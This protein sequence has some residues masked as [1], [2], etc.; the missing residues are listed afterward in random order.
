MNRQSWAED[1]FVNL[2]L[3]DKRLNTRLINICDRFSESPESPIN[4]ACNDWAETKGAYRFFSN[5]KVVG[6]KILRAHSSQTVERS[7]KYKTILALQ[8]TSYMIYTNHKATKGIGKI[9]MKKGKNVDK[10][11]SKGLILHSCLAVTTDGL[12]LGLLDQSI[13]SRKPLTTGK[14]TKKDLT[15]IEKKESY[16]WLKTLRNSATQLKGSQVVTV[17]DREADIYEFFHLSN[18]IK[19]PVL[20]RANHNRAI[21]KK[22]RYAEKGVVKLW[23]YMNAKPNVG[24]TKV[25][26]TK[27]S[28]T[29]HAVQRKDR[30]AKLTIKVGAFLFNPPRNNIK[31]RKGKLP[32]LK[33]NAI[34]VLEENPPKGEKPLE[35][36]LLTNLP[37]AN[38][39]Q[40]YEKIKWYCLRWRIEMFFKV[41]KSGFNVENCRL[42]YA[43]RL[44]KYL[45]VMT[46]VAWRLFMVTLIARTDPNTSCKGFLTDIEWK[47]LYLKTHKNKR[48]PK[49]CPKIKNVVQWIA[50]LGGF[51]AR[52]QDGDPGT[53]V[54]WR[55][56][57]RLKDLAQGWNLAIQCG[58]Y[59]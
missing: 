35:W 50:C 13:T 36:M 44:I 8:D 4:Q 24:T 25:K 6:D 16:R 28:T 33:M 22:S 10:I 7:K 53:L 15:P 1:E 45:T 31:L 18:E 55:G 9:S 11:F 39:E 38:L 5:E 23:E 17:C 42:G 51:L 59:G 34:Y 58:I 49:R 14:K 32:D 3:G 56:W 47:V 27:K 40:A 21:D 52:K 41:L 54:L 37:V 57:K 20:V 19:S 43:N 29:R 2:D 12:P 26:I 48:L 30:V 46:I